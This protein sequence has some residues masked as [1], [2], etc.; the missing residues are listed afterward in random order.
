MDIIILALRITFKSFSV[1][2][3]GSRSSCGQD[4]NPVG[5]A[6]MLRHGGIQ[7]T[8]HRL[9]IA[10]LRRLFP[11]AKCFITKKILCNHLA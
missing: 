9:D 1:S 5:A 4:P 2:E 3:T 10:A 6:K 8:R 11:A 7:H